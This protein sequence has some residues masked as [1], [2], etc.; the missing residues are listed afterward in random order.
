MSIQQDERQRESATRRKKNEKAKAKATNSGIVE[1]MKENVI[2]NVKERNRESVRVSYKEVKRGV[3]GRSRRETRKR[4]RTG[5]ERIPQIKDHLPLRDS[6]PSQDT[7]LPHYP[8]PYLC[9]LGRGLL[10][11]LLSNYRC[12]LL[13]VFLLLDRPWLL[14]PDS[15]ARQCIT[16][17]NRPV[18]SVPS[19]RRHLS[20]STTGPDHRR[21]RIRPRR[22]VRAGKD[23]LSRGEWRES[24]T[25]GMRCLGLGAE[26]REGNHVFR[27]GVERWRGRDRT[28]LW[29]MICTRETRS[30]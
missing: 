30:W 15:C 24:R 7:P 21:D 3:S 25:G 12:F 26:R 16:T 28:T 2:V 13:Y 22:R 29:D 8:A 20:A 14:F 17:T 6:S 18:L 11:L 1:R 27:E 19:G 9:H 4:R 23:R 10:N 5:G